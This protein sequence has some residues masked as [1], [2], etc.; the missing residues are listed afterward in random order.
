MNVRI[1]EIAIRLGVDSR[2]GLECSI[3]AVLDG[4]RWRAWIEGSSWIPFSCL[5][6]F[7]EQ[8]LTLVPKVDVFS[9]FT[10]PDA[11]V[12]RDSHRV[13]D[14]GS[15]GK[16]TCLEEAAGPSVLGARASI[17]N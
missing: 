1:A 7:E 12:N 3:V 13:I 14:E 11:V 10:S 9:N 2:A 15:G 5:D 8:E 6:S 17:E 4:K 16:D